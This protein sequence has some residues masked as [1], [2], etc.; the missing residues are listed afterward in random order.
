MIE[1]LIELADVKNRIDIK[2]GEEKYFDNEW[3]INE[4]LSEIEEVKDE[5]KPNNQPFLEDE[6]GDI[7]WD[8]LILVEKL[9]AKG[10]VNSHEAIIKRVVKKYS[11][12][13]ESLVG[14]STDT[15]RWQE[16][17]E[18]QKKALKKEQELLES[19]I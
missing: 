9:K 4:L 5:I 2:R 16:V 11:E 17:K 10:L 7:L 18:K 12:R 19:K 13:I 8:W 6:L 15:K 14:D 3:M 1:K